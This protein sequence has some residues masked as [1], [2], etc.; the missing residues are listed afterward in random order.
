LFIDT[1]K[2]SIKGGDGG[3]GIVA[4]QREKF[5]PFGGPSGGDG[6]D[7]GS[8]ILLCDRSLR[9]L[10]DFRYKTHFKAMRGMHGQGDNKSGKSGDDILVR[11][12]PGT[13][14][15]NAETSDL[16]WELVNDGEQVVAAKGGRAG[17]GNARFATS[18]NQAP[19]YSESGKPAEERWIYLE[20]KLLADAGLVGLPNAGKSTLL[21]RVS[22]ARPKIADYPFTTLEPNLGVVDLGDGKSF[23]LVDIPGL[24]EGAHAGKGL[25]HEFLRHIE[26]TKVLVFL[27]DVSGFEGRD[28]VE[29]YFTL[30]RELELYDRALVERPFVIAA[31][32]MDLPESRP[33]LERLRPA[34]GEG[35]EVYPIS[36]VTGEGVQDLMRAVGLKIDAVELNT[37]VG[38]MNRSI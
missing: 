26:R 15:R 21:S 32:K 9:T 11:V 36:A 33:H 31:N 12:P 23:V 7:G 29:D 22:A 8:V 19:R 14:V 2:I 4:F 13:I 6:G 25:G 38:I 35:I 20:L 3:N 1:A 10:V 5:V 24:I 27:V 34:V 18:T 30:R 17:R 37:S 28:P 16:L